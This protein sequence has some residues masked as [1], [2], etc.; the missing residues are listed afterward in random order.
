MASGFRHV[1]PDDYEP[2]LFQVKGRRN[3]RVTQVSMIRTTY[4]DVDRLTLHRCADIKCSRL[5]RANKLR[6]FTGPSAA[7]EKVN[8]SD[9][10]VKSC[11]INLTSCWGYHFR[12]THWQLHINCYRS[13]FRCSKLLSAGYLSTLLF[14]AVDDPQPDDLGLYHPSSCINHPVL[15]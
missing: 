8:R 14:L 9:R 1:D 13:E 4:V 5:A 10:I 11:K 15:F 3:V 2:A 12:F 6:L 7:I